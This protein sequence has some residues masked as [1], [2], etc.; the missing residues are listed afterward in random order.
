MYGIVKGGLG[1]TLNYKNLT[2]SQR[3][4]LNSKQALKRALTGL[5]AT[6]MDD[7]TRTLFPKYEASMK[8]T[9]TDKPFDGDILELIRTIGLRDGNRCTVDLEYGFAKLTTK[10]KPGVIEFTSSIAGSARFIRQDDDVNVLKEVA[11]KKALLPGA[12]G[13]DVVCSNLQYCWTP[14][15]VSYTAYESK[16]TLRRR[17]GKIGGKPTRGHYLLTQEWLNRQG[18]AMF[19]KQPD[20]D[21]TVLDLGTYLET[22]FS[23]VIAHG[24]ACEFVLMSH[25][26]PKFFS[27][28]MRL[29]LT[30]KV[31][32]VTKKIKK[33]DGKLYNDMINSP[34]VKA[35]YLGRNSTGAFP[36]DLGVVKD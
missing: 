13:I 29:K 2:G 15:R 7:R 21:M 30:R 12:G 36:P 31:I 17:F 4:Y 23:A 14:L 22:A 9:R 28:T 3:S 18:P 11:G 20:G 35:Y 5:S 8:P 34:T 26:A 10:P 33:E 24:G 27:D 16:R 32:A 19:G 6:Y 1:E 25:G